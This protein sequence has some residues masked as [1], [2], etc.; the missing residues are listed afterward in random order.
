[1][2]VYPPIL[3][4]RHLR[5]PRGTPFPDELKQLVLY[6]RNDDSASHK[7]DMEPIVVLVYGG[8]RLVIDGRRRVTR[9]I[10]QNNHTPRRALIIEPRGQP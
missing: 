5:H 6:S 4:P 3:Q 10:E 9:W 1:M 8:Q 7:P 2:E